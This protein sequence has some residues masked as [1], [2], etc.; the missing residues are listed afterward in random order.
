L[1]KAIRQALGVSAGS[2]L[3]F[4]LRGDEVVITRADTEHEDPAIDAFLAL[5]EADI[6]AGG[7]L[8]SLPEDLA[9]AMFA[10]VWQAENLNETING[11]VEL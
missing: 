6:H 2:R 1:P 8:H 11:D 9:Q 4:G 3:A 7:N 10:Y 5:M